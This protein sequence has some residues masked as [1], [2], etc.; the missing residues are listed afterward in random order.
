MA[1]GRILMGGRATS[2]K[3]SHAD[4]TNSHN[5]CITGVH[6]HGDDGDGDGHGDDDDG[7]GNDD[8]GTPQK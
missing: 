8:G 6:S 3:S 7:H 2:R 4:R 1:L 5:R